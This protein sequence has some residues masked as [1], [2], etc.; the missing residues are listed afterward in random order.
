LAPQRQQYAG[1]ETPPETKVCCPHPNLNFANLGG[2]GSD[3]ASE[4]EGNAEAAAIRASNAA[5]GATL[6]SLQY[7]GDGPGDADC[8]GGGDAVPP[9]AGAAAATA[10]AMDVPRVTLEDASEPS[11]F[12]KLLVDADEM[13]AAAA[14]DQ[15]G[16][17]PQTPP[18]P[19]RPPLPD[20]SVSAEDDAAGG[21]SVQV[22]DGVT[23]KVVFS[24]SFGPADQGA[25][26]RKIAFGRSPRC[27]VPAS[28]T[29]PLVS[30]T[31]CML[32]ASL[33]SG[34]AAV[35]LR[36]TDSSVNGTFVNRLR[37]QRRGRDVRSGDVIN[38]TDPAAM[39][40][41]GKSAVETFTYVIKVVE[42]NGESL[43]RGCAT[44]EQQ[45]ATA[46]STPTNS[47]AD[48]DS[49]A[50]GTPAAASK[51]EAAAV[52]AT[53][54]RVQAPVTAPPAEEKPGADEPFT[55][56]SPVAPPAAA[57]P[58]A[59]S[60]LTATA[61]GVSSGK[62]RPSA[63]PLPA[64][65][66]PKA[67]DLSSTPRTGSKSVGPSP[68]GLSARAAAAG[69]ATPPGRLAGP[70]SGI[71]AGRRSSV[72]SQ[73]DTQHAAMGSSLTTAP[74][75]RV[76]SLTSMRS[77][78]SATSGRLPHRA[79]VA[80]IRREDSLVE[81]H[82]GTSL[83]D[84][85]ADA[86]GLRKSPTTPTRQRPSPPTPTRVAADAAHAELYHAQQAAAEAVADAAAEVSAAAAEG[87]AELLTQ[88]GEW[89]S[90]AFAALAESQALALDAFTDA[91]ATAATSMAERAALQAIVSTRN[92]LLPLGDGP[93]LILAQARAARELLS[94][95]IFDMDAEE[96]EAPLFQRQSNA[97][98]DTPARSQPT[99]APGGGDLPG[100]VALRRAMQRVEST[101]A[102]LSPVPKVEAD[103][104]DAEDTDDA[105]RQRPRS[106]STSTTTPRQ[107][108]TTRNTPRGQSTQAVV[109]QAQ[110]HAAQQVKRSA[111]GRAQPATAGS[112]AVPATAPKFTS[113]LDAFLSNVKQ[114][115]VHWRGLAKKESNSAE[116]LKAQLAACE[117]AIAENAVLCRVA[118]ELRGAVATA[119]GERD[120]TAAAL[121]KERKRCTAAEKELAAVR[122]DR[123]KRVAAITLLERDA[124]QLDEVLSET[125]T[126][127]ERAAERVVQ[128]EADLAR[129]Q[130]A[131]R[132]A[133]ESNADAVRTATEERD[134]AVERAADLSE[135][136]SESIAASSKHETD[137][138]EL[139]VQVAASATEL[140]ALQAKLVAPLSA[141]ASTQT[142][143]Y[144][145]V[146]TRD[147]ELEIQLQSL[148]ERELI[149]RLQIVLAATSTVPSL[150]TLVG[151]DVADGRLAVTVYTSVA[152]PSAD[153][154]A[155]PPPPESPPPDALDDGAASEAATAV[156][157]GGDDGD[158]TMTQRSGVSQSVRSR[159]TASGK[160]LSAAGSTAGRRPT[161][162]SGAS[163]ARPGTAGAS[164]LSLGNLA[165]HTKATQPA[166]TVLVPSRVVMRSLLNAA[167]LFH[168]LGHPIVGGSPAQLAAASPGSRALDTGALNAVVA[169]GQTTPLAAR[170][171]AL[172]AEVGGFEARLASERDAQ[173]KL[174]RE[175]RATLE[176]LRLERIQSTQN[177]SELAASKDRVAAEQ[178]RTAQLTQRLSEQQELLSAAEDQAAL[179]EGKLAAA[180]RAASSGGAKDHRDDQL[181]NSA[182]ASGAKTAAVPL[183]HFEM[184]TQTP[185][186]V[187]AMQ[188][189]SPSRSSQQRSQPFTPGAM[190]GLRA[191]L[192]R[193]A[194]V[195]A[196]EH[197]DPIAVPSHGPLTNEERRHH[198]DVIKQ[199]SEALAEA[200]QYARQTESDLDRSHEEL[201]AA[202]AGKP[203]CTD[204]WTQ[205]RV[206]HE[207]LEFLA[208]PPRS[209]ATMDASQGTAEDAV[210]LG[211][212]AE[213]ESESRHVA[214]KRG[215]HATPGDQARE[216]SPILC[217]RSLRQLMSD[218]SAGN[219]DAIAAM[220]RRLRLLEDALDRA[221]N[222]RLRDGLQQEVDALHEALLP[223]DGA[224]GS[225]LL[226]QLAASR[227]SSPVARRE[228]SPAP[229]DEGRPKSK[230]P[231]RPPAS[232]FVSAYPATRE[233][234]HH[235]GARA[236]SGAGLPPPPAG[237]GSPATPRRL[238]TQRTPTTTTTTAKA[239]SAAATA[240]AFVATPRRTAGEGFHMS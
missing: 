195:A 144:T 212:L 175:L 36:V 131:L 161:R 187:D 163:P 109:A 61:L 182:P 226:E 138:A 156:L 48:L 96:A 21:W 202:L 126:L 73:Q 136:L 40:K 66:T 200:T 27:E 174:E 154:A 71:T 20:E 43:A 210:I 91:A 55:S 196:D 121:E 52:P 94:Q 152:K 227:Q 101:I 232:K 235:Q 65:A 29:S 102:G 233:M 130:D 160:F 189:G 221:D 75:A 205:L 50:A 74:L 167:E 239:S 35:S 12:P 47:H 164:S 171:T 183:Q 157:A 103:G 28:T 38:L 135:R 98:T 3:G 7:K 30:R 53:P 211:A 49:S 114:R 8:E 100:D 208:P 6:S 113:S 15:D 108:A 107:P 123:D 57:T 142:S 219:T 149:Q 223:H 37:L 192:Q 218:A 9:V 127:N 23:G 34:C 234:L 178:A 14:A 153:D 122:D 215:L 44:A 139:R 129:S 147:E 72:T 199:L 162:T 10:P 134:S 207:P 181:N 224:A 150:A 69:D 99:M 222:P 238:G 54:Q 220:H 92:T 46:G 17:A 179:L 1:D 16:A 169:A 26:P 62:R 237:H 22:H 228:P 197:R 90:D 5:L 231:K 59:K 240:P 128:L 120:G 51:A 77:M 214:F 115:E 70:S 204:R 24:T 124:A 81:L 148:E 213:M 141:P 76:G 25:A 31:H 191:L 84:S 45:L 68:R 132:A 93:Q 87:V 78:E 105:S 217:G 230:S 158:E 166:E 88:F 111:A 117:A 133:A 159:A 42:G 185:A 82:G 151:A 83:T 145:V 11:A 203:E 18:P 143:S 116:Q 89:S 95:N 67:A 209:V 186:A 168:P 165:S 216:H 236:V 2:H 106:A 201:E 110:K 13:T 194:V 64:G 229:T 19:V 188:V 198:L 140:E 170:I 33:M 172:T 155:P 58:R 146:K 80:G 104:S 86:T 190:D 125:M 180:R 206:E 193:S 97:T 137:A 4:D 119:Q 63:S 56:P 85:P 177:A 225:S 176:A 112:N 39:P 79:A 184:A 118:E 41:P 173:V 32:E 60:R